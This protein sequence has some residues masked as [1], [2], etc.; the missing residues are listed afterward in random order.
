M[1]S[2]TPRR[3]I[4]KLSVVVFSGHFDKVHYAL[5]LA[6]AA[7][8]VEVLMQQPGVDTGVVMH[9]PYMH[10]STVQGLPSSQSSLTSQALQSGSQSW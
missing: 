2:D 6:A 7:V 8:A 10:V 4:D 1:P 5:T 9:W 3:S